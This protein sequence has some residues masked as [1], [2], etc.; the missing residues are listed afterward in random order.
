M[1]LEYSI[2]QTNN[3]LPFVML[4]QLQGCAS[5]NNYYGISTNKNSKRHI[6]LRVHNVRMIDCRFLRDI[7]DA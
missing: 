7:V 4:E 1:F 3:M 6:N 2:V 5:L